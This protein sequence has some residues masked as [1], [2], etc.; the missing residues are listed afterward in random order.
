MFQFSALWPNIQKFR[1]RMPQGFV[2]TWENP[3]T[4]H[5]VQNYINYISYWKIYVGQTS[6]RGGLINGG[7]IQSLLQFAHSVLFVL[8][9]FILKG[10]GGR[11]RLKAWLAAYSLR[12]GIPTE[13]TINSLSLER[14]IQSESVETVLRLSLMYCLCMQK[15]SHWYNTTICNV[16]ELDRE[17][18]CFLLMSSLQR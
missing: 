17:W 8:F 11:C 3:V 9:H 1:S 2:K 14:L 16:C 15:I 18:D 13:F 6:S 10:G 4:V 7:K 5:I 12:F